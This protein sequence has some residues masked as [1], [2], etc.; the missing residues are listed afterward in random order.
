[1]KLLE[2]WKGFD[3]TYDTEQIRRD[4][5]GKVI[6]RYPRT[7]RIILRDRGREIP[8]EQIT[9]GVGQLMSTYTNMGYYWQGV[10]IERRV[11]YRFGREAKGETDIPIYYEPKTKKLFVQK[12]H[13]EKSRRLVTSVL[14]LRLRALGIAFTTELAR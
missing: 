14:S 11:L 13:V 3:P 6:H 2:V 12:N 7:L 5:S 10:K 9:K 8:L 4:K 1:M